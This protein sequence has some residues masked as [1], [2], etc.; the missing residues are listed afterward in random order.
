MGKGVRKVSF[1]KAG[2]IRRAALALVVAA[3]V[4]TPAVAK[5]DGFLDGFSIR[6]G[7][8]RPSQAGA[9]SVMDTGAWG[10]GV[11]YQ[12][13]WFPKLLNGEG[14]TTSIS[15]DFHYSERSAGVVRYFPVA[16]NQVYT[17]EER[18][19]NTP[20]AGFSLV[21]ATVGSTG[22]APKQATVTRF[23]FGLIRPQLGRAPLHRGAVRLD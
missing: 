3:P 6:A 19:G 12:L 9:R 4:L 10:I 11:D 17:F 20:Y 14:W 23:G 15:A 16:I 22:I 7:F 8:Y 21:A 18:N 13:P 2:L 5:A 1:T